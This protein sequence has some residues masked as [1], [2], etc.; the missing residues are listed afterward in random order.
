MKRKKEFGFSLIEVN[1]A[2]LIAAGGMLSLFALFPSGLRMSIGAKADIYQST[3]AKSFFDAISANIKQI[4]DVTVWN[5]MDKF[6]KAAVAGTGFSA[7]LGKSG[8]LTGPAADLVVADNANIR[9]VYREG[10]KGFTSS[11]SLSLL[12][13]PQYLI[14]VLKIQQAANQSPSGTQLY[15]PT[16]YAISL[17]SSDQL[18]PALYHRNAVYQSEF[19]FNKRP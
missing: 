18:A 4:E 8:T 16:R 19:Y 10:D 6:W 11:G 1:M 14:R 2:I 9:Y 17:I 5:D 12:L 3:F 13:P 7:T 15:Y